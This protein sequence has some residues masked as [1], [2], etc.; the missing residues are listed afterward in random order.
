MRRIA[1]AL[2]GAGALLASGPAHADDACV[3]VTVNDADVAGACQPTPFPTRCVFQ[4]A[5][6]GGVLRVEVLVCHP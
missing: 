3:T 5:G 2:L 6:I 4:A 1:A